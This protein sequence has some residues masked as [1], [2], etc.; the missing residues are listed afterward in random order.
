MGDS[1]LVKLRQLDF[2]LLLVLQALLR[3]RQASAAARELA[4]SASAISHALARLRRLFADPLFRRLP[5]GLEPTRHALALAP[6]VDALLQGGR[7]ALGQAS[8][9]AP[10]TAERD[11]RLAAPDHLATILA[12]PLLRH[13]RREAPSARFALAALLG[14]EALDDLRRGRIDL[15]LGQFQGG[16]AGFQVGPLYVDRYVLVARR[17]RLKRKVSLKAFAK[18]EHVAISVAGDF[19]VLTETQFRQLGLVRRIV[20]TVPRFSTAFETVSRSDAVA[21]APERFARVQADA[22]RLDLHALPRPLPPLRIVS[23]RR[24]QADAGID[25]LTA[26]VEA[27]LTA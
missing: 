19:R 2:Q 21:I 17:G 12:P 13:F 8:S 6:R 25:W 26:S 18:L 27:I 23:V 15:A 16:L 4:L 10:A 1:N 3:H 24:K 20:A 11:F 14:D 22:F 7:E 5:H 9:F